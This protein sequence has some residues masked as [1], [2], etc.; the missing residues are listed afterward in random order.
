L[1]A[2]SPGNGTGRRKSSGR[3]GLTSQNATGMF[4]IKPSERYGATVIVTVTSPGPC[5]VTRAVWRSGH[6]GRSA[7]APNLAVRTFAAFAPLGNASAA[8]STAARADVLMQITACVRIG[9]SCG[10]NS[11]HRARG[12]RAH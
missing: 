5:T 11:P 10:W 1:R 3:P 6:C 9:G 12:I 7:P 2:A 8:A 4:G